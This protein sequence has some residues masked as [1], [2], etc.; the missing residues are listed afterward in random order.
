M[1]K[2][3]VPFQEQLPSAEPEDTKPPVEAAQPPKADTKHR[4]PFATAVPYEILTQ[5][6]AGYYVRH[7]GINE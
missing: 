4:V 3:Q 2:Q 5:E 6:G 7:W 1:L